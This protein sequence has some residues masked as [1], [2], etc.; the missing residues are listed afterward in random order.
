[1]DTPLYSWYFLR[2]SVRTSPSPKPPLQIGIIGLGSIA[3]R[4]VVNLQTLYPSAR[5]DI[6]TKRRRWSRAKKNTR[7]ISS[8]AL[9]FSSNR[10]A[11]FITN[12]TAQH[13]DTL[14]ACLTQNPRGIFME[15]PLTHTT[16]QLSTL[17]KAL[18]TYS[19]VFF[20]GYCLQFYR[21][22]LALRGLIESG[23]LGQIT[24]ITVSAG[25]DLHSWR[26]RS[27]NHTYSSDATKGGGVVLDLIHEL[28]YPG[29][30]LNDTLEFIGSVTGTVLLKI[31]AEDVAQKKEHWFRY[32]RI[33]FRLLELDTA[34]H[35][36]AR[37]PPTGS[38]LSRKVTVCIHSL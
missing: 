3:E 6:L 33:T 12:E 17:R 29:W 25:K 8:H 4:H 1:M 37:V 13:G 38:I 26:K 7:L 18:K 32:T 11:Y 34:T 36:E 9:F 23:V 28:N 15:K 35:M 30:L 14:L 21:P 5:I 22:L 10:D 24:M 2:V 16:T 31:N 27:L 19:G 20:V